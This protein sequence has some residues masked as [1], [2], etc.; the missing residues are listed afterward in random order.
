MISGCQ[1]GVSDTAIAKAI[2]TATPT[3]LLLLLLL[4][5]LLLGVSDRGDR[6]GCQM[7]VSDGGDR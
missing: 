1:I 5:L 2:V 6:Y 7:G 3:L 4:V